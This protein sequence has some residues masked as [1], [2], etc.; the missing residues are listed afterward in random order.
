MLG[1]FYLEFGDLKRDFAFSRK[2][3]FN[4]DRINYADPVQKADLWKIRRWEIA[5]FAMLLT[6]MTSSLVFAFFY[7]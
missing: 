2:V 4:P 5:G 7:A 3:L 1:R 6:F